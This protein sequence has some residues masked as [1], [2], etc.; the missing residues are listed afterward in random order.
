MWFEIEPDS[1]LIAGLYHK[2]KEIQSVNKVKGRGEKVKTYE[3]N[4]ENVHSK[5]GLAR[6]LGTHTFGFA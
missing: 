2:F 5:G 4:H 6:S 3:G 1:S